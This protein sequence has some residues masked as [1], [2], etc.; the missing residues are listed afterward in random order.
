[1]KKALV[2]ALCGAMGVSLLTGCGTKAENGNES[3]NGNEAKEAEVES[4]TASTYVA[5]GGRT[6]NKLIYSLSTTEGVELSPEDFKIKFTIVPVDYLGETESKE[7]DV[8]ISDVKVENN[9]VTV[10]F[11][12]VSFSTIEKAEI[13]CT[14]DKFDCTDADYEVKTKTANEFEKNEFTAKDGTE[15]TYYLYM[16]KN[17]ENVPLMVWE[18]GGGE[19]LDSSYEGANLHASRGAVAWIED[20]FICRSSCNVCE[21]YSHS[22][23]NKIRSGL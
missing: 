1:M 12:E 6:L 17:E 18:H 14:D 13:D 11:P 10:E 7:Q 4:V 16:P 19:V 3:E 15:L 2:L 8:E 20:G 9:E 22:I 5:P 21:R 23:I